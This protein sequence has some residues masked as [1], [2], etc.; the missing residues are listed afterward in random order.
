MLSA[1]HNLFTMFIKLTQ[2]KLCPVL[3]RILLNMYRSQTVKVKWNDCESLGFSM[4]T[5]VKQDGVLSPLLFT[6][7]LDDLLKEL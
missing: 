5:G 1:K 6:V 7:Y 4:N 2:R 3:M